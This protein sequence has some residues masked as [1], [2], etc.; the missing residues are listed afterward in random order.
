MRIEKTCARTI[1]HR[2]QCVLVIFI[3][4]NL[5]FVGFRQRSIPGDARRDEDPRCIDHQRS[6]SLLRRKDPV[7]RAGKP[8][9]GRKNCWSNRG[10]PGKRRKIHKIRLSVSCRFCDRNDKFKCVYKRASVHTSSFLFSLHT[11]HS[12]AARVRT[13]CNIIV[14]P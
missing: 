2:K 9:R 13:R 6:R 1:D 3:V 12:C 5:S 4:K 7:F 11:F 8:Q 14:S 10:D